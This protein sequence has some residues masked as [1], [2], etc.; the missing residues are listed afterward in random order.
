VLRN[1]MSFPSLQTSLRVQIRNPKCRNHLED[2]VW[3][4]GRWWVDLR[5]YGVD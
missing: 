5:V 4:G 1:E 2:W 3:M